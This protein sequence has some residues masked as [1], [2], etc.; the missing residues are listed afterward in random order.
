MIIN[1]EI[2]SHHEAY[3]PEHHL[4]YAYEKEP[5]VKLRSSLQRHITVILKHFTRFSY[6]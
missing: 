3:S 6:L 2:S 5:S 4:R 1:A